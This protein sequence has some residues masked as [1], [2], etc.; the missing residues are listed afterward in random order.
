MS[1]SI[2]L[3]WF[4]IARDLRETVVPLYVL[5][6]CLPGIAIHRLLYLPIHKQPQKVIYWKTLLLKIF[7]YLQENACVGVSYE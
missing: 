4:W 5:T 2:Y 3:I 6:K 1:F 7:Q